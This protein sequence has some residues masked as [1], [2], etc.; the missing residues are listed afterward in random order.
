MSIRKSLIYL[1][2]ILINACAT[3]VTPPATIVHVTKNNHYTNNH[4]HSSSK[5]KVVTQSNV[6]D[7]GQ[8]DK[9]NANYDKE[10]NNIVV[11]SNNK[12]GNP[13]NGVIV[14]EFSTSS[15]GVNYEGIL[16]QNIKAVNDG[17]VLYS[18][19]ALKDYGNLIIV[20]HSDNYLSVYGYNKKNLVQAG[21]VVHRGDT[22]AL[23]GNKNN[24]AVLH[25]EIRKQGVP[26]DPLSVIK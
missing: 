11:N 15:K 12:W 23:M 20:K 9:H 6:I 25:F 5:N 10:Q 3:R 13:T 19:N 4:S 16:G 7:E 24:K 17:K 8:H 21:D 1:S 22:I 26:I 14:Q 18:G 2:V